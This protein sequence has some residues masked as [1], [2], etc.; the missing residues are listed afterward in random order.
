MIEERKKRV[1]DLYYGEGKNTREIASIERMS[2]RDI[3][4]IL[5]EEDAKRQHHDSEVRKKDEDKI[6]VKAYALFDQGK[7]PI[8]VAVQLEL[9]EPQV[10]KYYKEYL[11]LIELAKIVSLYEEVG[12]DTWSYL[13]LHRFAKEKGLSNEAI[14]KAVATTLNKLPSAE[15]HC[16]A[17]EDEVN[18]LELIKKDLYQE[19]FLIE[20]GKSKLIE[21]IRILTKDL[22]N[23]EKI[24]TKK[25]AEVEELLKE[26]RGLQKIGTDRLLIAIFVCSVIHLGHLF[27]RYVAIMSSKSGSDHDTAIAQQTISKETWE[28]GEH[29]Q[30]MY[31]GDIAD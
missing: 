29:I 18:R 28:L 9:R 3:S 1:I 14:V 6:A 11:R 20:D 4:A 23:L 19:I 10:S 15:V 22:P 2:I 27:G 24:H 12:D 21:K 30:E 26:E 16:R 17:V 8:Q 31:K 25:K 13:E 7:T 5:N